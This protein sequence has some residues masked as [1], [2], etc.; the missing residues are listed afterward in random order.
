VED[1]GAHHCRAFTVDSEEMYYAIL[2]TTTA[3]ARNAIFSGMM[4]GDIQ[5]K[6]PNLWVSDDDDEGKNLHE[7][8]FMEINFQ[9][10]NQKDKFS[11]NKVT[12]LHGR[13]RTAG[14]MSNLHNNYKLNVIVY[15]FVDM[16]SAT[17]APIWP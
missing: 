17:P 15:N 16:L 8:E 9:K 10:N 7:S 14:Q 12:N 1:S 5:K 4:P 3:Y 2:P 6:Y 11:Y 13:Q